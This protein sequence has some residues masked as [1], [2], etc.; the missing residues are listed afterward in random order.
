ML[1]YKY[2]LNTATRTVSKHTTT[3]LSRY[4]INIIFNTVTRTVTLCCH[5]ATVHTLC[6][7]ITHYNGRWYATDCTLITILV[8]QWMYCAPV[9]TQGGG[10]LFCNPQNRNVKI[11]LFV[12]IINH[13]FYLSYYLAEIYHR[14][15]SLTCKF[16]FVKTNEELTAT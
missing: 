11:T 5:T 12:E 16:E 13:L 15:R 10:L 4:H 7:N 9:G 6:S 8:L 1:S 3:V 14:T 2:Y